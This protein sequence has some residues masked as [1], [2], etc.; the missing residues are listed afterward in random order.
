MRRRNEKNSRLNKLSTMLLW[1]P[2]NNALQKKTIGWTKKAIIGIRSN[3][4][5]KERNNIT[6]FLSKSPVR[7]VLRSMKKQKVISIN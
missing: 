1:K 5:A 3:M 2:T 7:F 6:V 4:N